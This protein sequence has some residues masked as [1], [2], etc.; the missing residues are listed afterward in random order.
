MLRVGHYV[1]QFFAGIGGEEHANVPP[2]VR[3]GPVGPG[4]VLQSLLGGE[5]TVVSTLICGDNFFNEHIADA[6]AAVRAWIELHRLHVILAGPAFAAGRYGSACAEVCRV[7]E[8]RR[9][10][11]VCGLHPENP[12][13]PMYRHAYIVPT[14][15]SAA[16]MHA[17]LT[18]MLA[19]G[20]K[21]ALGIPPEPAERD[22]YLPRGIR[23]PGLRESTGAARAVGMLVAK[24][25]GRPYR[26]ELPVNTYESVS[27]APRVPDLRRATIAAVTTG[28]LVPKGNPDHLRR[29]SE[30]RWRRYDLGGRAVLSPDAFECVH[31]GFY[32]QTATDNPQVILPLDALRAL[33]REGAFA[34]LLD[35]YCTTTG[36]D[37]RLADCTRNGAEIAETLRSERVD[38]VLLVAT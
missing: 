11:A 29:C 12:G 9:V 6:H 19:L 7:A 35:F 26:T 10:P 3:P 34:R 8:E 28:A 21:L 20:R 17:A 13:V 38:G 31:G 27:P 25:H 33:E 2:A 15:G 18:A 5:G 23:R 36:N 14:G 32:N 24:L 30:T 1:N 4:R 22:G 16:D 37:Q